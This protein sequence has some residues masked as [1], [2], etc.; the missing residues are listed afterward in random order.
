MK[1]SKPIYTNDRGRNYSWEGKGVYRKF[2]AVKIRT[3]EK[4]AVITLKFKQCGF[5]IE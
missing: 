3:S 4:F 1:I 5:T 2:Y